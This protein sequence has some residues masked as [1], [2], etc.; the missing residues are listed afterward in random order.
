M[1]ELN[2]FKRRRTRRRPTGKRNGFLLLKKN[3]RPIRKIQPKQRPQAR[4]KAEK[5]K[6]S[7]GGIYKR[8]LGRLL[9]LLGV[10]I[11]LVIIIGV[12][13][14]SVLFFTLF[15]V[16]NIS[17]ARKDIRL[18]GVY[19][20]QVLAQS[21]SGKNIFLIKEKNV[22]SLMQRYFPEISELDIQKKYPNTIRVSIGTYPV[23]VRWSCE[24]IQKEF[25]IEGEIKQER[26]PETYYLN[27]KGIITKPNKS[28]E[29]AFIVYEKSECP[30]IIK[31]RD[32]II[33]PEIIAAIKNSMTKIEEA[34]GK[35]IV[36]AGYYR[37]AREIHF[38]T[39]DETAIWVDF[40][41][42]IPEQVQKLSDAI[43][44]EPGLL[45]TMDHIDLRIREKIFYAPQS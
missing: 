43:L 39:E 8:R 11:L 26:I 12:I 4:L 40:A 21:Y 36:R 20:A 37:D 28:E 44:L 29:E 7:S 2:F 3:H 34:L 5:K 24:R 25:S 38:Y 42:P 17:V 23:A 19:T 10:G 45:K 30:P 13:L 27:E 16:Q 1:G 14:G 32:V 9:S 6:K 15:T 18:E 33:E 31:K 41:T 22:Q 35:P